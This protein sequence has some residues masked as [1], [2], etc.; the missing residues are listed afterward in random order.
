MHSQIILVGVCPDSLA[1]RV[2]TSTI[3][4][5]MVAGGSAFRVIHGVVKMSY[6]LDHGQIPRKTVWVRLRYWRVVLVRWHVSKEITFPRRWWDKSLT[7]VS[8]FR[9]ARWQ[10]GGDDRHA[11]CRCGSCCRHIQYSLHKNTQNASMMCPNGIHGGVFCTGT[12][13]QMIIG[14][15]QAARH[16]GDGLTSMRVAVVLASDMCVSGTSKNVRGSAP[17]CRVVHLRFGS[18][19]AASL[20]FSLWVQQCRVVHLC[21]VV[22]RWVQQCRV[23]HL[24]FGS[25][26]AASSIFALGPAVPRHSSSRFWSSSAASFVF[27]LG[28]AVPRRSSPLWVP[29]VPRRSSPLWVPAVPALDRIGG[30]PSWRVAATH[31]DRQPQRHGGRMRRT[32]PAAH[33][34]VQETCQS[35]VNGRKCIPITQMEAF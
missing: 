5:R 34:K 27:A 3:P 8:V 24:R 4:R 17:Q 16:V 18:S 15:D 12:A 31:P 13:C 7:S 33:K 23:V 10:Y 26:S 30:W 21:R 22:L 6:T 32:G 14:G 28:P 20:I 2:S 29:A 25:S 35:M 1:A 19:S 11:V 9:F